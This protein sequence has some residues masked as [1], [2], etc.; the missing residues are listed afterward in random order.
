ME[1]AFL[2][3]LL[4]Y[5][6]QLCPPLTYMRGGGAVNPN[7]LQELNELTDL[8]QSLMAILTF[9]LIFAAS[10]IIVQVCK[11]LRARYKATRPRVASKD[12]NEDH[13]PMSPLP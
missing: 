13:W 7:N 4:Y 12:W 6:P 11:M 10:V 5:H 2:V 9:F 8:V 3:I 1:L